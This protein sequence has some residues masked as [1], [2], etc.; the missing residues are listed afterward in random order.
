MDG[1]HARDASFMGR[2]MPIERLEFGDLPA[3]VASRLAPRVERLGYLGEFFKCAGHQPA[4]LAAFIDFTDAGKGALDDRQVETIALTAAN[5]MG[6]A[7]ERHQHER[8]SV[9]LGFGREWV[10]AV[11][12]LEP[13]APSAMS[14]PE[15]RIQ[16]L[17]LTIL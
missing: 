1:N 11:N 14:E 10:E 4:A 3:E 8:L 13:D 16:K 15:R 5:W 12:R 6:N 7:Y 17:V 9:R 2:E